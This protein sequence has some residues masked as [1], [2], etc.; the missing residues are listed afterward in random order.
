MTSIPPSHSHPRDWIDIRRFRA[1]HN[2][3]ETFGVSLFEPKD[4]A[5]L[6]R[7]DG[8]GSEMNRLRA[9][10]I[11]AVPPQLAPADLLDAVDALADRFR[12]GLE[13][14]N[15]VIGLREPEIDFAVYGLGDV[16]RAWAYALIRAAAQK[17]PPPDFGA[18][19]DGWLIDSIRV[20]T[21]EHAYPHGGRVWTIRVLNTA[22]GRAGL[23]VETPETTHAVRETSLAC[24]AEGYMAA[25]LAE[26][27][28]GI[29]ASVVG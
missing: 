28:A 15:P 21:R 3:P 11:A 5:V 4:T 8:A 7:I 29:S 13:A 12:A 19:Y 1:D 10:L 18:V 2:L 16:L 22:Y 27:A 20:S 24:P 25:L 6:G 9:D 14:I 17:S 26:I 23:R